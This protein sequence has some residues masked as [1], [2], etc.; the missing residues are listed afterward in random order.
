MCFKSAIFYGKM[1]GR[2]HLRIRIAQRGT[3]QKS[4]SSNCNSSTQRSGGRLRK[5]G[6]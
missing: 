1:C 3:L 4:T 2:G 5:K 6:Q